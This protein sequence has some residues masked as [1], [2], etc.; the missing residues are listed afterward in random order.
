M[1]LL[2]LLTYG[3]P[4]LLIEGFFSGSEIALLSADKVMLKAAIR[5]GNENPKRAKRAKRAL[6]LASHPERVLSATLLMAA[7][8]VIANSTLVTLYLH[9]IGAVHVEFWTLLTATPL[10]VIFGELIPKTLYQQ[11]ADTLAPWLAIPIQAVYFSF[12]PITKSISIYTHK[13]S[14]LLSPIEKLLTGKRRSTRDELVSIIS[15]GKRESE[16]KSSEKKLIRRI[17]DFKDS[18]AKHALIP[19]VKVD[20][21]ERHATIAEALTRFR[22][23]RH[24]RMP[25]FEDR[26]DNIVGVLELGDLISVADT[27]QSIDAYIMPAHYVA[28]THALKDLIR[29]LQTEDLSLAVVVDEYGGAIGVLSLEDIIEEIVGEIEDEY[30]VA[31]L[32]YRELEAGRSWLIQ[33]KMEISAVHESLKIDL[34]EGD[35]ETIAGFLLQ[36]FGRIPEIGDE[37]YFDTPDGTHRFTIKKASTRHI[38]AVQ[39]EKLQP[40]NS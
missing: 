10:I 18:E 14:K 37:L 16:I 27:K 8:C 38:D 35:Y 26:I 36:Q 15:Y 21:L 1:T 24:S 3:I 29:E 30:D 19:L 28:E 25:V 20:A 40:K 7:L 12:Y 32:P 31:H 13:L 11:R 4:L 23:H 34:P 17:L 39:V 9:S 6:E 5:Q 33:G 2:E 22:E